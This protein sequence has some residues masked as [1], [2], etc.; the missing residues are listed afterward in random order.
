MSAYFE[1]LNRRARTSGAGN[2][3]PA[4]APAARPVRPVE[5]SAPAPTPTPVLP[6]TSA[7]LAHR[8]LAL[9][10]RLLVAANGRPLRVIVFAGCEGG[11][12]SREITRD[13]SETLAQSG[14]KVM[15]LDA[16]IGRESVASPND[17]TQLVARDGTAASATCGKGQL[18][19]VAG[20][21]GTADKEH[22][23]RSAEFAS[24]LDRQRGV[25]DY[26][27]IDAPPIARFA[28]A[29][30]LGR[31]CDGVV[32]VIEA[33]ATHRDVLVRGREQLERSDV[34]VI[35]AVLNRVRDE[36]PAALRPY[37]GEE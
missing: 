7:T 17:V 15:M 35:G 18:T 20:P 12:G 22:F 8:Y 4:P 30:L 32:I 10:E 5:R 25:Y 11:E 13:F 28:D 26:A 6:P 14:L 34:K 37:F 31:L 23:Y 9:R 21:A 3:A 24:W 29:T 33:G 27:L 19:V 36:L 16:G 2:A 1:S